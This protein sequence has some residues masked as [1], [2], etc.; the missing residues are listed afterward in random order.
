MAI[1]RRKFLNML[2]IGSAACLTLL[3]PI[4]A[5]AAWASDAFNATKIDD[6]YKTLFGSATIVESDEVKLKVP[7]I[8]ENG[9]AVPVSVKTSMKDV[10]SISIF[11]KDNPNPLTATFLIPAGTIAGASTRIRLAQTSTITAIIKAGGKLYSK[12]Q[13]VKVTIG[14]C[15]G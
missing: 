7:K 4:S 2:T 10:E 14:G 8:A 15:G 3:T 6:A 11:V 5:F 12:S 13:E 9:G 1:S